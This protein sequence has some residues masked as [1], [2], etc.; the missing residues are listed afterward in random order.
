[1]KDQTATATVAQ[2]ASQF[3]EWLAEER[4]DA[5]ERLLWMV[6]TQDV[7]LDSIEV[8]F[9]SAEHRAR[10]EALAAAIRRRERDQARKGQLAA[11][12][13]KGNWQRCSYGGPRTRIALS[14]VTS[15]HG[16]RPQRAREA[17]RPKASATRSSARSGD[18]GKEG[19]QSELP[20]PPQRWLCAF[21]GKDIPSDRSPKATHC[22]DRHADRDRQRRK[23][24]RDRARSKLPPTPQPADYWRMRQITDE[25]RQLLRMLVVCRCNGDHLEFEPGECFR[26]GRRLPRERRDLELYAAF[27]ASIP[28]PTVREQ[29][30][31]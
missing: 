30:A 17:R 5:Y 24:Q 18:S 8:E 25:E 19:E 20:E 9:K 21:C 29:V 13:R 31:A 14:V 1:M 10:W 15:R 7:Q 28:W 26:C 6:H 23:R 2:Q 11:C 12:D 16:K 27:A 3:I 4:P 22:T